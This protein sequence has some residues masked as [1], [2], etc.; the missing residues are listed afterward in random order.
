MDERQALLR[1]IC[2]NPDDDTPRLVFA[3]WLQEHG[4]ED[5]AE[6]IRLQCEAARL[7]TKDGRRAGLVRK[8]AAIQKRLGKQWLSELPVPDKEHIGWPEAPG[9][10][11]GETF[12]RGFPSHLFV[13]TAGTLAKHADKLFS[14]TPVR[15][16]LIWYIK[17]ANKLAKLPQ[18]RHLHTIRI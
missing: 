10:L 11:D 13:Q 9:W 14:A 4:E 12:D 6:F 5:R 17:R 7:P 18:L 2:E 16:L 8:A 15:R 3:D 1:A